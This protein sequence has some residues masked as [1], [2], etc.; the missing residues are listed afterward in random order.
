MVA[1]PRR[2]AIVGTGLIGGSIGLAARRA[3]LDVVGFD[4][5]PAALE[6]AVARGAIAR[7]AGSPATAV[8]GADVVVLATPVDVTPALCSE[9]A[10]AAEA[11][12]A[13]T[14]VGSAKQAVVEHGV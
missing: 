11:A 13:I 8:E 7:G 5:D 1:R 3:D 4:A 9:V 12:T 6:A 10:T 2:L 14:D